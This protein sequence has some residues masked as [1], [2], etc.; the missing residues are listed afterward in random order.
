MKYK[1]AAFFHSFEELP[2]VG[3]IVWVPLVFPVWVFL[4]SVAILLEN[5]STIPE[6]K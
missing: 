2:T 4:I 3:I 5:P 1:H 6:P